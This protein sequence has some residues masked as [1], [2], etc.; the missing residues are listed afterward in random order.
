VKKPVDLRARLQSGV[1]LKLPGV[2][3]ALTA[4]VVE[5]VGFEAAYVSG[6]GIANTF[7][8]APDIGLVTL[9]EL[10]V[11]V[12][13]IREA[14]DIPLVVDADTGFG[15]PLGVRRTVRELARLGVSA[16]QLEDQVSPKRCGHFDGK[17]VIP[18][19]EMIQ[20]IHAALDARPSE[21]VLIIARTDAAA[22]AGFDEALE[23]G[24]RY[25]EAGADMI[26]VE[27]PRTVEELRRI[28]A[29]IQTPTL[30]NVVEGGLTPQLGCDELAEMGFSAMLFANTALRASVRAMQSVL[31][32]L[33]DTGD[34]RQVADQLVSWD[35]RQRLVGMDELSVLEGKYSAD[36]G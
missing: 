16:I 26:F 2:P 13:A 20:K 23:R 28:P 4:R 19:E 5:D 21:D 6:A 3:N 14:V 25:A 33:R 17:D 8:G 30:V 9:S 11:H 31:R 35:E 1:P 18:A 10:V 34:T 22:V 24:V 7:L 29:T 27:A 32:V 36:E 15:N 12:A